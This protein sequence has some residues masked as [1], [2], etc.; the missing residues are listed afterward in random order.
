MADKID[1]SL[2]SFKNGVFEISGSPLYSGSSAITLIG[3]EFLKGYADMLRLGQNS[4]IIQASLETAAQNGEFEIALSNIV[5]SFQ[6]GLRHGLNPLIAINPF[7]SR[8]PN[9]HQAALASGQEGLR[10]LEAIGTAKALTELAHLGGVRIK[11]SLQ[12]IRNEFAENVEDLV[13][14]VRLQLGEQTTSR[15]SRPIS[16]RLNQLSVKE[17]SEALERDLLTLDEA[18]KYNNVRKGSLVNEEYLAT[19]PNAEKP[20][21]DLLEVKETAVT[22]GFTNLDNDPLVRV[23]ASSPGDATGKGA[24]VT[25][26]SVIQG[27]SAAEI[28]KVLSLPSEPTDVVDV[29]FDATDTIFIRDGIAGSNTFGA[30]GGKQYEIISELKNSWFKNPRKLEN[31]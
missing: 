10:L 22:G 13:G 7:D 28:K 17:A 8:T 29:V 14:R 23:F 5:S 2:D 4:A 1:E 12:A 11:S 18:L 20:W 19:K 31:L 25:R 6:D 27:K 30:G 3:T 15:I 9:L 21:S 16:E 26:K 24:W